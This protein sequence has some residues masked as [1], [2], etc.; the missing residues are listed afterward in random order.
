MELSGIDLEIFRRHPSRNWSKTELA[1]RLGYSHQHIRKIIDKNE[2]L[3]DAYNA[4]LVAL[5]FNRP[6]KRVTPKTPL[7]DALSYA[8]QNFIEA[9]QAR[10]WFAIKAE[11]VGE[12]EHAMR[13]LHPELFKHEN[14]NAA[15][16]AA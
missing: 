12:I 13:T 7:F 4:V 14:P 8:G 15:Q 6:P 11:Q 16:S 10:P 9:G 1:K 5:H 3:P 2:P